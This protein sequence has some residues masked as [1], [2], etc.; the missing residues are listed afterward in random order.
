MIRPKLDLLDQFCRR[1]E[2]CIA[3][4]TFVSCFLPF[5]CYIVSKLAFLKSI[6]SK[7]LNTEVDWVF[8]TNLEEINLD[9]IIKTYRKRWRIETQFR[10]QDKAMIKCKSKEMKIRY[11]IFMFE[12]LLQT[13]WVCFH[14]KEEVSFKEFLIEMHKVN[15]DIVLHPRKSFKKA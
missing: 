1:S 5:F 11:F 13:L 15:K 10:V 6:F 8:A 14:K 2:F 12:Q 4:F 3:V 7:R 9:E